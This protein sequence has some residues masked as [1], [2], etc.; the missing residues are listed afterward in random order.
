MSKTITVSC[1]FGCPGGA[2]KIDQERADDFGLTVREDG[3]QRILCWKGKPLVLACR[4]SHFNSSNP[5]IVLEPGTVHRIEV[6]V[7]ALRK[8]DETDL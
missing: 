6:D 8:K 4:A 3:E 5:E 2:F 7:D 1:S